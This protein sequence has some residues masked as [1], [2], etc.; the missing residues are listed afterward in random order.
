VSLGIFLEFLGF[1]DYF[2]CFKVF[3]GLFLELLMHWKIVGKKTYPTGLGRAREPDPIRSG[4]VL[5]PPGPVG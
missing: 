4:P 1:S 5:G 2:S 3:F